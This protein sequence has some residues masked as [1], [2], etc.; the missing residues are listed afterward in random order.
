[1]EL[2]LNAGAPAGERM[3]NQNHRDY[4]AREMTFSMCS[5]MSLGAL[6]SG[7]GNRTTKK[8]TMNGVHDSS[9]SIV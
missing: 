9:S 7:L 5:V 1:M 2:K 6:L 4:G 8:T 3:R